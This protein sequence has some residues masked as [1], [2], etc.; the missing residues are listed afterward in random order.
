MTPPRGRNAR[1]GREE[2][3]QVVVF[4]ALL[5]PV[6]FA[7]AAIVLDVGNWYVH[8][9]HLQTQ[10]DAA[11]LASAV[12]FTNC[13]RDPIAA[14]VD[15]REVALGYAGDT[16]RPGRANPASPVSTTNLQVQ[17]PGDVRVVL[18]SNA[19]W[20]PANGYVPGT[21]GYGLDGTVA[22]PGDPCATRFLDAKA[23]DEDAPPLWGLLPLTPS[24]KSKARVEIRQAETFAGTGLLPFFVLETRPRGVFALFVNEN[25]GTIFD[26]QR[27]ILSDTASTPW[28][29]WVTDGAQQQEVTFD[30]TNTHTGI[31]ILVS[32]DDPS[33]NL[34]GSLAQVCGQSPVNRKLACYGTAS[35]GLSFIHGYS[36]G[37]NGSIGDPQ[38]RQVE[39]NDFGCPATDLSAPYF[40]LTGGAGCSAIVSAVLDFGV[41]GDPTVHP[42]CARV[43]GYTWGAG[44]I[45]GALGTWTGS[46]SLT[47][48]GGRQNVNLSGTSGPRNGTQCGNPNQQPHSFTRNK[49]SAA[50]IANAASGPVEY[51]QLSATA[52]VTH[53]NSIETNDPSDPFYSYTVTLGLSKPL[54]NMNWDDDPILLRDTTGPS[55]YQTW[56]CD[57]GNTRSEFIN[58]CRTPYSLNYDDHDGDGDKEWRDITC[59]TARATPPPDCVWTDQGMSV[60]HFRDGV[61]ARWRSNTDPALGQVPCYANNWPESQAEADDFFDNI[62][63]R[64]DPRYVTLLVTREYPPGPGREEIPVKYWAGFYV[65]GWTHHHVQAPAC[66]DNDPPPAGASTNASLWGYYITEVV[67]SSPDVEPS[68]QLCAFGN[69]PGKCVAILVE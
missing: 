60:G 43:P 20:T 66:P 33:P 39:L 36:G 19:F 41:S 2:T 15:I 62:R 48:G 34:G 23:T 27:L 4:F 40:T 9:R 29:E 24:P 13:A 26:A 37:F 17:E 65:T 63:Y 50:Y 42:H 3:G 35:A 28:V 8:K 47:A 7:L 55:Q 18:N 52:P 69:D 1:Y 10:V 30:G 16:L 22:T 46:V 44:G 6:L 61:M 68:D 5:I 49:V 21:N 11:V 32:S 53:A 57:P 31:V 58:G 12:Q 56:D 67:F 54:E 38:V 59:A 51:L 64:D 14:N 25:N 45:G